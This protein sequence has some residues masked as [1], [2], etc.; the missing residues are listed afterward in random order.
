M[1]KYAV[2]YCDEHGPYKTRHL[3]RKTI[4]QILKKDSTHGSG[5]AW[6]TY[7]EDIMF[8]IFSECV[9]FDRLSEVVHDVIDK[10]PG[11]PHVGFVAKVKERGD[12]ND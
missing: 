1:N 12:L 11:R 4:Q 6:G 5:A 10:I 2:I 3:S 9:T 7:D 8:F